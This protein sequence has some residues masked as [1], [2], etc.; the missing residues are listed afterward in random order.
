[1]DLVGPTGGRWSVALVWLADLRA[2]WR[3]YL[4][5]LVLVGFLGAIVL[6]ALGGARRTA[7]AYARSR[8]A[9]LEADVGVEVAPEYHAAVS[10]LPQV[11]A[12]AAV[13]YFFVVLPGVDSA[14]LLS[15]ASVD[16][17]FGS[18][19]D[20]P[21]FRSGRPANP[22]AAGEVVINPV[23][24]ERL[25]LQ[26][27]S[28]FELASLSPGQLE[29][30]FAGTDPGPPA[31]PTVEAV[32]TGIFQ[33]LASSP[34]SMLLTPA[35]ARTYGSTIGHFDDLL[36]VR[37]RN[38]EADV[39]AFA[40]GV[41]RV[42]PESAEVV[43]ESASEAIESVQRAT[44]VQAIGLAVVGAIAA[45]GGGLALGALT[46][47]Q[48][49]SG[50]ARHDE[51]R[52]LGMTSSLRTAAAAGPSVAAA[53][54]GAVVA[55]ALACATSGL[56]PVGLARQ[57]E[58][59]PG[60]RADWLV[61]LVGVAVIASV[62]S[63]VAV[64]AGRPQVVRSRGSEPLRSRP[65]IAAFG[66]QAS[67]TRA[68]GLSL[69]L[70][71]RGHRGGRLGVLAAILGVGGVLAALVVGAGLD[72]VGHDASVYGVRWDTTLLPA[73]RLD[74]SGIAA[75]LASDPAVASTATIDVGTARLD[76]RALSAYALEGPGAAQLLSPEE[77][78]APVGSH[79]ILVG[80]ATL[81][82]LGVQLGD[83]LT[84]DR[85]EGRQEREVT[86][87]GWGVFPEIT[88]PDVQDSDSGRFDDFALF[89]EATGMPSF[90]GA[91]D[92]PLEVVA[93]R[94]RPGTDVTRRAAIARS[95]STELRV[96]RPEVLDNLVRVSAIPSVIAALVGALG[97]IVVA[98]GA[99]VALLHRRHDLAVLRAL[100]LGGRQLRSIG[101]WQLGTLG[102][103]GLIG[104]IPLGIAAGRVAWRVTT[105]GSGVVDATPWP[106][107]EVALV[108]VGAVLAAALLALAAGRKAQRLGQLTSRSE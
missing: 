99:N 23:L 63:L 65:A 77:G 4:L 93:V 62:I 40:A 71:A 19:V 105:S 6:G 48:V 102:I 78:R 106:L 10:S 27:G 94:W 25:D 46:H 43:V 91:D 80:R 98:Y 34:P 30:L 29:P 74:A 85:L 50:A 72:W 8:E 31:G 17:Q 61:L 88:D 67:P 3:S 82:R 75:S 107:L 69:A 95:E 9:S 2:R 57:A 97:A 24:A 16:E 15:I 108:A 12:A 21:V 26:V 83:T 52:A 41:A 20:R 96:I 1:M 39:D 100:G 32:V 47:R 60:V 64:L 70:P 45:I 38:G 44:R 73:D 55:A 90:N 84:I 18:S 92:V 37:L 56:M 11:A 51:L 86:I 104:G 54:L 36:E 58:P 35:F 33:D 13:S 59:D 87:V 101:L 53:C 89:V 103:A 7:S 76:D 79:E 81:A 66:G 5:L 42:V 68:V 49:R 22:D 28:V 14:E